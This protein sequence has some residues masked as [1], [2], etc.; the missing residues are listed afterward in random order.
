MTDIGYL[1]Q[2]VLERLSET[3]EYIAYKETLAKLKDNPDL[4]R[5]VNELRE[6]N[7]RLT[8]NEDIVSE[9]LLELSD[10]LTNEYEDV[11][12]T[13]LVREFME[14]EAAFCRMMQDFNLSLTEGLEF[15]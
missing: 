8:E 6:K 1:V 14:A 7:F 15:D 13:E 3:P 11:I 10:A 2:Y 12:N 4:Y 5:K 9:D